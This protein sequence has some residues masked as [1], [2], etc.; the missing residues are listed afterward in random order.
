MFNFEPKVSVTQIVKYLK[1]ETTHQLW[2]DHEGFLKKQFWNERTFR[3]F[4]RTS[5]KVNIL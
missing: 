3:N 5:L 4:R 1:R 2:E